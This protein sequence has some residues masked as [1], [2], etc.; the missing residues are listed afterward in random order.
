MQT[1]LKGFIGERLL[2]LK[3][4]Y[5]DDLQAMPHEQLLKSPGGTARSGYDFTYEVALINNR[6]A[7]RLR[8]EDP[9][10]FNRGEGF[11]RAP[12]SFCDK[13]TAVAEFESSMD[14]VIQAW[15]ALP[16]EKIT[17]TIVLPQGETSAL[18]LL[19]ILLVHLPYHDGQ[20]N[21][22]QTLDSDND[23]HWKF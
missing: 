4:M 23:V 12:E 10:P 2:S 16:E 9:G 1:D 3:S 13:T 6:I 20:L 15:N 8:G 21:Y 7:T 19:S 5:L 17:E 18:E 22:I 14:S 11:M